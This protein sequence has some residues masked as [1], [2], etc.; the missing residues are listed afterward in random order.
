MFRFAQ[1]ATNPGYEQRARVKLF[2]KYVICY[3]LFKIIQERI[4][5]D[6]NVTY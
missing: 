4:Y 5:V 3:Q 2:E 6:N 1:P